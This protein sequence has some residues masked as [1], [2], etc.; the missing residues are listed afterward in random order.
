MARLRRADP[1]APGFTRRRR[2]RGFTYHDFDGG[3]I[4]DDDILERIERLVIPPAWDDVW[5]CPHPNGH[6]QAMGTD[7]KGRRQYR[8]HDAWRAKRD[9]EK[10][11]HMVAFGRALPKIRHFV[12]EHLQLEGMPRERVLAAAVRL[13]DAGFFR[14]GTEGYTEENGS[15]GLSTIRKEHVRIDG[16]AIVF[17]YPGK[18]GKRRLQAVVDDDSREV[19]EELLS[20][21]GGGPELL[22][23]KK[24]RR[25]ADVRSDDINAYIKEIAGS[26]FSAKDFRTWSATVLACVALAVSSG[27]ASTPSKRKRAV[28]RMYKEVSRYLGNTPAVCRSSYVDPR[29]VDRFRAGDTVL[30]ALVDSDPAEADISRGCLS[31]HGAVEEA[32]V[33]MLDVG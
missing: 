18:S 3:R 21:R 13:L 8:Y 22:A 15:V 25:W 27:T 7:A 28:T 5:I 31:F 26:E 11:Q 14:I 1:S 6:I 4:T 10:F 29:V 16:P 23:Y 20:R 33:E 30:D 32:V 24:G 9:R 19:V 12:H 2:G 17:D